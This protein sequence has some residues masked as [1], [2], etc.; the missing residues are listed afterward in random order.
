MRV[1]RQVVASVLVGAGAL[2][3][4]LTGSGDGEWMLAAALPIAALGGGVLL[5]RRTPQLAV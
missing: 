5:R 3:L 4:A 2:G 1:G